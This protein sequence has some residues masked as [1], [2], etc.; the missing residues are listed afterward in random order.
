MHPRHLVK[1]AL[2]YTE[3]FPNQEQNV[4]VHYD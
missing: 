4:P 1:T 3:W 2:L